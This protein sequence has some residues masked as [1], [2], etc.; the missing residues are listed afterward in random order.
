M[1]KQ[2]LVEETHCDICGKKITDALRFNNIG[3]LVVGVGKN[4]VKYEDICYLCSDE[5][6]AILQRGKE[7]KGDD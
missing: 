5:I 2:V 1:K 3:R 7:Q 6:D 4:A